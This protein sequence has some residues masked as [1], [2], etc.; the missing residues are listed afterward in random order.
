MREFPP[1]N[2]QGGYANNAT[3]DRSNGQSGFPGAVTD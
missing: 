3:A 2:R 1:N